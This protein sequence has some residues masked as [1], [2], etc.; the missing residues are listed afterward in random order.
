VEAEG[1]P[2]IAEDGRVP[3]RIAITAGPLY[4]FD[5]V[6]VSGLDHLRPSFVRKRFSNLKGKTLQPDVLDEKFGR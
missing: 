4:H 3:V 6:T 1:D 5:D 2:T